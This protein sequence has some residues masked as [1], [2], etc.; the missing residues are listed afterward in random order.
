MNLKMPNS[1]KFIKYAIYILKSI[2][3]NSNKK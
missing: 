3:N 2:R 1:D